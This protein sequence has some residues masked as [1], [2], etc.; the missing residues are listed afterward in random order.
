MLILAASRQTLPFPPIVEVLIMF[1]VVE[2]MR[3]AA[4]RLPQPMG[5]TMGTLDA[6]VVGTA[7]VAAGVVSPQ[8]IVVVTLTA[9]AIF[10]TPDFAMTVPW[11]LLMW[12]SIVAAYFLGV[13]GMMIATFLMLGNLSRLTSL[14]IPYFAP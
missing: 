3:E 11:R 4:L 14:G 1:V 10:T 7:V 13:Y 6:I 12:V 8:M 9:L 5:S 2:V